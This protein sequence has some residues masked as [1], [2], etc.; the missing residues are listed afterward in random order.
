M[1]QRIKLFLYV[2]IIIYAHIDARPQSFYEYDSDTI[3]ISYVGKKTTCDI[4]EIKDTSIVK[5]FSIFKSEDLK[6]LSKIPYVEELY[7]SN[8]DLKGVDFS[9]LKTL[10]FLTLVNVKNVNNSILS[11]IK[12]D[13]LMVF[14]I[15]KS[16]VES[17]EGITNNQLNLVKL[18]ISNSVIKNDIDVSRLS[19]LKIFSI[20]D[21]R[22]SSFSCLS[23]NKML[24][25]VIIGNCKIKHITKIKFPKS[26]L[27]LYLTNFDFKHIDTSSFRLPDLRRVSLEYCKLKD[28][29]Y[30]LSQNTKIIDIEIN[31]SN[32]KKV[33]CD[34]KNFVSLKA[35][36][37]L[38]K[39]EV[40]LDNC[41]YL[42]LKE[43]GMFIPNYVIEPEKPR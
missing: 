23:F 38:G 1:E 14:G 15:L 12:T 3:N 7:I 31:F 16:K 26:L 39:K 5:S 2:L 4:R 25:T 37:M 17:L 8:C 42:F 9:V 13:S 6:H 10:K 18:H 40:K 36:T 41:A 28:F 27:N 24:R 21:V 11:T 22:I 32:I 43:R 19:K 20:Y 35:L 33:Q 34:I 29:P 30:F